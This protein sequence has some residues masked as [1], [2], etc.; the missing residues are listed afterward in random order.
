M[1]Y[2]FISYLSIAQHVVDFI[3]WCAD[4]SGKYYYEEQASEE[5]PEDL[6]PAEEARDW[7]VDVVE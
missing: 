2:S 4:T 5:I 6:Q 7:H 1:S 3:L